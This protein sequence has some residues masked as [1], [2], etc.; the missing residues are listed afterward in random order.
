MGKTRGRLLA[1]RDRFGI[2]PLFYTTH[3]DRL[4]IASEIKALFA[5]GVPARWDDI[6]LHDH[7]TA[8]IGPHRTLFQGIQQVPPGGVL[9]VDRGTLSVRRYWLPDYPALAQRPARALSRG[10]PVGR[11]RSG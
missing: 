7:L 10:D 6:S 3:G 1:A 8:G 5:A 2:K 9:L 4:L 11:G